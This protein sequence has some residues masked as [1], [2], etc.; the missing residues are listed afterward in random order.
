MEQQTK[1]NIGDKVC[2]VGVVLDAE[3][4]YDTVSGVIIT[5]NGE[6]QYDISDSGDLSCLFFESELVPYE[7]KESIEKVMQRKNGVA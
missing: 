6:V 4:E 7:H 5:K 2:F 1:F 3:Y